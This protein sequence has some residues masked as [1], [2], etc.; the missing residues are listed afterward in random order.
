[1]LQ[2]H[3]LHFRSVFIWAIIFSIVT[4]WLIVSAHRFDE[5]PA[6]GMS[7]QQAALPP[8]VDPAALERGALVA[9]K[10]FAKLQS[11]WDLGFLAYYHPQA[12]IH[13]RHLLPDG[14]TDTVEYRTR[15]WKSLQ[16]HWAPGSEREEWPDAPAYS[17]ISTRLDGN[18]VVIEARRRVET[19]NHTGPYKV[20][21][22]Q[23]PDG[24]W[25]IIEEWIE[26]QL[27]AD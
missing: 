20:A 27:Y 2:L 15:G 1:M 24:E 26:S 12:A 4:G 17:G 21:L 19:E 16:K 22:V 13:L 5:E 11:K 3:L 6:A 23:T 25:R 18:L 10:D 7:T 8:D 9:F 14:A